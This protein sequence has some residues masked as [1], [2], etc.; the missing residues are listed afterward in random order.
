MA[1]QPRRRGAGAGRAVPLRLRRLRAWRRQS[2]L[3]RC[4]LG[5]TALREH[6][7]LDETRAILADDR[8]PCRHLAAAPVANARLDVVESAAVQPD[9]VGQVRRADRGVALAI[10]AV[11][12]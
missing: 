7:G 2:L 12:G 8:T 4:R 10:G 9:V 11:A 5:R 1:T 3:A 6:P